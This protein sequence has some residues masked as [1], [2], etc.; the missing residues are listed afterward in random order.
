MFTHKFYVTGMHCS[1]CKILLENIL[2]QHNDIISASVD[3]KKD[4]VTIQTG[5]QMQDAELFAKQLTS[6]TIPNGYKILCNKQTSKDKNDDLWVALPI[7][8]LILFIFYVLQNFNI[9]DF[10]IGSELTP[11]TSFFIGIVASLS[12]C[13]AIVGGL[14]LSITA[15]IAQEQKKSITFKVGLFH[16]SRILGF[17]IL[18]GLLGYIG[19]AVSINTMFTSVLGLL[20]A[21][22]MT[23]LGLSLIGL[24]KFKITLPLAWFKV[25]SKLQHNIMT[26]VVLGIATFFL[27]CGFTQSMQV[28]ALSSGN[29]MSGALLMSAFAL[30]T[31][32]VLAAL[33]FSSLT[34]AH[35]K[36]GKIFFKA[37]GII[38]VGLGIFSAGSSLI[39]LGILNPIY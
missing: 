34:F 2:S 12:S 1:S 11:V 8:I 14:I 33:S 20:S 36:Y 31:F 39:G 28:T 22:I 5:I 23:V 9:L 26:P 27:P 10:G 35:S 13:L 3:L 18:G 15:K 21:F 19:G 4:E 17:T 38:V 30:G 25:L 32:P 7:G 6:I 29:F 37:V 16:L 24:F